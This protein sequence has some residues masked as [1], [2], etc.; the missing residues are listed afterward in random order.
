MDGRICNAP[1]MMQHIKVL[2]VKNEKQL[3]YFKMNVCDQ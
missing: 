3:V 1:W 2:I